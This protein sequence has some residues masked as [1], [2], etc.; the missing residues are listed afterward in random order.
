MSEDGEYVEILLPSTGA[1]TIC[2]SGESHLHIST[3]FNIDNCAP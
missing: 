1:N 3:P 2:Q